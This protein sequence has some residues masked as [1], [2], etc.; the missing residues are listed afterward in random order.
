MKEVLLRWQKCGEITDT[1]CLV[2]SM[3]NHCVPNG[4]WKQIENWKS[5]KALL[6]WNAL[7]M[8]LLPSSCGY[9]WAPIS[10]E[11]SI[12]MAPGM[13]A[14][15]RSK[16]KVLPSFHLTSTSSDWTSFYASLLLPPTSG[17]TPIFNK[18]FNNCLL[19]TL[20]PTASFSDFTVWLTYLHSSPTSP[21]PP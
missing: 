19:F 10:D 15:G 14:A 1:Q 12:H 9:D 20:C 16:E 18:N 6:S 5:S 11:F 7:L 4:L 13:T 21:G 17:H 3:K 8:V 2:L